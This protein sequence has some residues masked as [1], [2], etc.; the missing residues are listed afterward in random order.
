MNEEHN[1]DEVDAE[2]QETDIIEDAPEDVEVAMDDSSNNNDIEVAVANRDDEL[3]LPYRTRS[4][5]IS[6]PYDF[7]EKFPETTHFQQT[8]GN[9]VQ[10]RTCCCEPEELN[11][12]L[13]KGMFYDESYFT[14]DVEVKKCDGIKSSVDKTKGWDDVEQYQLCKEALSWLDYR[15][16]EM[17]DFFLKIIR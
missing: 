7:A 16:N 12:K 11:V 13:G 4:G 14:S 3:E 10:L 1:V 9:G 6:K 8:E 2:M 5:R 15:S 17:D